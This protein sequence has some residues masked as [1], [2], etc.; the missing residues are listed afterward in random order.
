MIATVAYACGHTV[1]KQ[2]YGSHLERERTNPRFDRA[3]FLRACA[4]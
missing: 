1:D 3:R 2:L 4:D